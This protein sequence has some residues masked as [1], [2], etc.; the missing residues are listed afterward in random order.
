MASIENNTNN[1]FMELEEENNSTNS[2][3]DVSNT[4]CFNLEDNPSKISILSW[5]V[6]GLRACIRKSGIDFLTNEDL[7]EYLDCSIVC[8]QETKAEEQQVALS[9]EIINKYPYRFWNST[10]GTTQRKGLS[11]TAIWCQEYT[12][13]LESLDPPQFDEEG[14]ITSVVFEKFILINVYTP[15]SQKKSSPRFDYRTNTWDYNFR[16][17]VLQLKNHYN[18]ELIVCGD[19][20]VAHKPIDV[21][22]F[23]NVYNKYSG[24][25][26]AE[27]DNF[28]TLLNHGLVDAFRVFDASPNKYSF[29]NQTQPHLRQENKGWRI[30]YFIISE[31]FMEYIENVLIYD[32]LMGSDHCP[33]LCIVKF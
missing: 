20:N 25:F 23:N 31:E 17:Y 15:N 29:W 10:K 6:A 7:P 26:K 16:N 32:K 4:I 30:D 22:N 24:C 1:D 3:I 12:N 28:D 19:L 5:N 27:I 33:L 21:H 11:G 8:F 14:R 2:I 18:K 13:P 9:E